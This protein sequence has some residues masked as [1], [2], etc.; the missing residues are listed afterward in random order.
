ML[1]VVVALAADAMDVN[2]VHQLAC[3]HKIPPRSQQNAIAKLLPKA[4][5]AASHACSAAATVNTR[6]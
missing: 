3:K 1:M 5:A 2:I 6:T 4:R